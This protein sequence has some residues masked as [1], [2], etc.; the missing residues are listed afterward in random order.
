MGS[1]WV[2]IINLILSAFTEYPLHSNHNASFRAYSKEKKPASVLSFFIIQYIWSAEEEEEGTSLEDI[3]STS[4]LPS[5][6]LILSNDDFITL[7]H[8][9]S[10]ISQDISCDAQPHCPSPSTLSPASLTAPCLR[11]CSKPPSL[12]SFFCPHSSLPPQ[13]AFFLVVSKYWL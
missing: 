8:F 9:I 12:L 13:F 1:M 5:P 2:G 7:F 11:I 4:L 3:S 6:A 10:D